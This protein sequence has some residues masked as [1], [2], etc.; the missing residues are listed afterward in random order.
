MKS[1]N[2]K[3]IMVP[4]PDEDLIKNVT[5]LPRTRENDGYI[6]VNLKRMK[7]MKKVEMQEVVQPEQLLAG[8]EYLRQ[9]HPDY[10]DVVPRDIIEEFIE[11]SQNSDDVDSS[12]ESED[13]IM[14][15]DFSSDDEEQEDENEDSV[16]CS[17]T[18]LV[19]ENPTAQVLVNDTDET[20]KKKTRI[21]SNITTNIAPGEGKT[22]TNYMREENFLETAFPRHYPNGK[23]GLFHD[24]PKKLSPQQYFNQRLLNVD[25][26]FSSDYGFLFVAQ[27]YTERHAIERSI[28]ICM[29]KGKMVEDPDG[30]IKVTQPS[31]KFNVLKTV[32][33]TPPYWQQL[34][35]DIFAKIEQLG[36]FHMF[37]T[38]SCAEMRWPE[39]MAAVLERNGHKVDFISSPRN[40]EEK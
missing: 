19:P 1:N 10:K 20:I 14:K 23:Y 25:R 36:P 6:N 26:R 16:F 4:I 29:K 3:V 18:C 37:F 21:A 13:E 17:V 8:L 33:G 35:Y 28:N 7:S 40:G 22:P 39:M 34:R 12:N 9:N 2:D 5:S 11:S 30:K 24:R 27:Q 38:L 15:S 31:D 32:R